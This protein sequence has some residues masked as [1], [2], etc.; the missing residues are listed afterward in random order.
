M[1]VASDCDRD[2][3]LTLRKTLK[4]AGLVVQPRIVARPDQLVVVVLSAAGLADPAFHERLEAV[5]RFGHENVRCIPV[6]RGQLDRN[7]VEADLAALNWITWHPDDEHR[8]INEIVMAASGDPRLYADHRALTA[9]AQSWGDA[10]KPAFLLIDHPKRLSEAR[11]VLARSE[12]DGLAPPTELLRAYVDASAA[13]IRAV[14]RKRG[15]RWVV[16]GAASLLAVALVSFVAVKSRI[17][18]DTTRISVAITPSINPDFPD[19][20][21]EISGAALIQGSEAVKPLARSVMR[22]VLVRPWGEG[23]IGLNGDTA[24]LDLVNVPG[25]NLS[26]SADSTGTV[27]RW[28]RETG[29]PL[30]RRKLSNKRLLSIDVSRDGRHFAAGGENGLWL[31]T[32]KPWRSRSVQANAHVSEVVLAPADNAIVADTDEGLLVVDEESAAIRRRGRNG[33]TVLDLRR[34]SDG[35][36]RALIRRGGDL[37]LTNPV[38]GR[39]VVR[40][41]VAEWQFEAASIAPD[42]NGVALR[43]ASRQLLWARR[44]LRF[45][46]TGIAVTEGSNI[47][48]M[49]TDGWVVYGGSEFGVHVAELATG[50]DV[51]QICTDLTAPHDVRSVPGETTIVCLNGVI[52]STWDAAE[53][54]PAKAPGPDVQLFESAT[55]KESGVVAEVDGSGRFEIRVRA[56]GKVAG[57]AVTLR[58]PLTVSAIR[59]GPLFHVAAGS[60]GGRVF[61]FDVVDGEFKLTTQW[62]SPDGTA[63]K[64]LGWTPTD[65]GRLHV[66]TASGRWWDLRPCVLCSREGRM[67]ELARRRLGVCEAAKSLEGMAKQSRELL[68]LRVCPGAPKVL[69][70]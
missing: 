7:P 28:D 5:D 18:N 2:C 11:R 68:G 21:A 54:Q 66:R 38:T 62:Q 1:I 30:E 60:Q 64:A 3:E 8:S 4:S 27:T 48:E 49:L 6:V 36:A 16:R 46:P 33:D 50:L 13:E 63:V 40:R 41:A 29:F 69:E 43:A 26:F 53:F 19:R 59:P 23:A 65:D 67:V 58:Y 42:G 10:G 12:N 45:R 55:S 20:A 31:G 17:T 9:E 25:E 56:D 70:G 51:G 34:T 37:V 39:D 15:R 22:D 61:A 14:R 35:T 24:L 52:T 47:V 44:D 32:T 57:S